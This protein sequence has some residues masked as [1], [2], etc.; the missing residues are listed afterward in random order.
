MRCQRKLNIIGIIKGRKR[1]LDCPHTESRYQDMLRTWCWILTNYLP[2][3]SYFPQIQPIS[4][5]LIYSTPLQ[6]SQFL[7]LKLEKKCLK[8]EI[9]P[10]Q[11][12]PTQGLMKQRIYSR[13][14][15]SGF[16]LYA[17]FILLDEKR[18]HFH[19]I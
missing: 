19:R 6:Q 8:V 1:W 9:S 12:P 2:H 3:G 15:R 7:R 11:T 17:F 4:L 18:R 5:C 13:I 16:P 14:L 10:L